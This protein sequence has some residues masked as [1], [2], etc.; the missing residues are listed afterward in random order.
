MSQQQDLPQQQQQ[1]FLNIPSPLQDDSSASSI[2]SRQS[3]EK[4]LEKRENY[5]SILT[6]GLVISKMN[7]YLKI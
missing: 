1:R 7:V 6:V 2:L 3:Q 4:L 5:S